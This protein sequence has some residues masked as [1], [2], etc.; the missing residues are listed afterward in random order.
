MSNFP[1]LWHSS[2]RKEVM[3]LLVDLWKTS[4]GE[5]RNILANELLEGPPEELFSRI[6]PEQREASRDRRIFDRIA[7]LERIEDVELTDDLKLKMTDLR[8]KYP[9]WQAAP[10]EQAHFATWFSV[11]WGRDSEYSGETLAAMSDAEL[12]ER[13]VEEPKAD[14]GFL[15]AWRAFVIK[16]PDR[17]LDLLAQL[18]TRSEPGSADI[19]EYAN[20][21]LRDSSAS[22]SQLNKMLEL[23]VSA[24]DSLYQKEE[25]QRSAADMLEARSGTFFDTSVPTGFWNLFDRV[26]LAL[27]TV[28]DEQEEA[29]H[30]WVDK[31]LNRPVGRL[32]TAFINGLFARKLYVGEGIPADLIDRADRLMSPGRVRNR[33]ARVIGASRISYLN[34]IDPVWTA[35]VLLPCFDWSEEEESIAAWQGYGWQARLDPQ[36]WSILKPS[37]LRLFRRDRLERMEEYGRNIAQTLMLAGVVFGHDDLKRE[38]VRKAIREMQPSL[39]HS[40]AAWVAGYMMED[41]TDV[42]AEEDEEPFEDTAD[43]KWRERIAPWLKRAWP[44]EAA[45]RAPDIAEEFALAAIATSDAFPDAVKLVSDFAI[46]GRANRIIRDLENSSHPDRYPHATLELVDKFV[47]WDQ[48]Q[49]LERREKGILNRIVA[50]APDLADDN[51][52]RNWVEHLAAQGIA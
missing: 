41:G 17:A 51:R 26:L 15:E 10:G 13:L 34:A 36:L 31:A 7:V 49:Y 18:I 28:P 19:W 52:Y 44:E 40:A 21:G 4:D 42:A 43:V 22:G 50:A 23:L 38:D 12:L 37:F 14:D 32:T 47:E 25:F 24:P 8:N 48:P 29:P 45:M 35:K 1:A 16:D 39:R 20:W 27:E 2:F 9:K 6:T 11:G 30:D 5:I 33:A 3:D 46:A